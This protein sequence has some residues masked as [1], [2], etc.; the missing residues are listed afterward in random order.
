MQTLAGQGI[1]LRHPMISL[2]DVDYIRISDMRSPLCQ[3]ALLPE[4]VLVRALTI[5]LPIFP[6]LSPV[7][8]EL[9]VAS[10]EAACLLHLP[11]LDS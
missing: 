1:S 10:L 8:Q 7:Q 4:S 5:G 2:L 9:V 11:V 6:G 3:P